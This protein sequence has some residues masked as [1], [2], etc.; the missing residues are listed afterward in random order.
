MT[1][2]TIY[3]G[4]DFALL[5]S[6]VADDRDTPQDLSDYHITAQLSTTSI[7]T[8]II[9]ATDSSR[10]IT[11]VRKTNSD[12]A[13]NVTHTLT[14]K[15]SEGTITLTVMLTHKQTGAQVI[16]ETKTIEIKRS[17]LSL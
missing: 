9:A 15:L 12:L 1:D 4:E 6:A 7:G 8:K 11:I 13:V 16:A 17:K 3:A 10:E 5:M 2:F 14:A